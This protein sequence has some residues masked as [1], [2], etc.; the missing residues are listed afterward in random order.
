[1]RNLTAALALALLATCANANDPHLYTTAPLAPGYAQSDVAAMQYLG[2]TQTSTGVNFSVYSQHATEVDLAFFD[3]P[4]DAEPAQQFP[5]VRMGDVWNLY[6]DGV[7]YGQNYGYVAW[8]P[9]WPR[10]PAW[11]PGSIAG[12]LADVDADGN[13]FDPN[14]LLIDPYARAFSGDYNWALSPASGPDRTV[15]DYSSQAKSVVV[16]S[17]YVW[18]DAETTWQSLRTSGNHP[19]FNANELVIYEM[20]PKGFTASPASGVTHPGTFRGIGENVSYL[21]DLGVNAVELMPAQ[22]KTPDGG[23]WG[24]ET[25]GFFAPELTYSS[26]PRPWMVGDEF[27]WMVDTLHQNGLMV[28]MD[29]VYNHTGEGGLWRDKIA[30]DGSPDPENLANYDPKEVASVLGFRGLDNQS[31]YALSTDNQTYWD[32][33]G[34]GNDTRCNN[35]PMQQLILDSL[36]YWVTE[37]HVD[38]F[39]FDLAPILAEDDLNYNSWDP[40][41]TIIQTIIDDPILL[42]H[43]TP[44]IAEPWSIYGAFVGQFPASTVQAGAGWYE[45]N[46]PFRDWWRSFVDYDGTGN[47]S[48]YTANG[49][50]DWNLSTQ[51]AGASG[52]FLLT[53]SYDW[54][55]GTGRRPYNSVNFTNIHD[56]FTMY[57]LFSYDQPFNGCGPLDSICCTEA[58][59]PFCTANDGTSDNRSRNWGAEDIKRAN[60]RALFVAM[61]VSQGTPMLLGGDEWMRTQL[62]NNNA[63]SN[64]ADNAYNWF[65]WGAWQPNN[66]RNRMHDFVRQLVAFRR[67]HEYA[68]APVDYGQSAPFDWEDP[69]GQPNSQQGNDWNTRHLAVHYGASSL[70]P[71]LDILINLENNPVNFT[72]P[73]GVSWNTVVDTQMAYDEDSYFGAGMD[74]TLSANIFTSAPMPVAGSYNVQ[75]RSIVILE[76]AK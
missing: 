35:T 23:Y 33:T 68:F 19:G 47:T 26:D 59:S 5:M 75:A 73:S 27:K 36:H 10:D 49:V 53:G 42:Q 22:Q 56:G 51:Q 31:Y 61:M 24:Y 57:D 15:S 45:W 44:I 43:H 30:I 21:V 65:D 28:I 34:V 63:Y 50:S 12:F 9:N 8:G 76:E 29:V 41:H 70:G 54:Y 1:M 66:E 6:V 11:Y 3:T 17:H 13:R 64:W 74:P 71:Q 69:S 2:A 37:M 18:S 16:Q 32:N 46:G 7:G 48:I 20:H 72:L 62:G 58:D 67:A 40:T 25:I 60:M 38:G 55:H 14:K 52:G 39:R 4:T